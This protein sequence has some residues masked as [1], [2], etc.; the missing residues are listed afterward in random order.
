M[1]KSRKVREA[2]VWDGVVVDKS[3]GMTDGSSLYHY[4]EV[5]L[6]DGTAQKFRID[7][8]LWNSLNTG[9][10]LVKEAGAKA[11]VKG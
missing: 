1:F 9:D 2:D 8:A 6:Q 4:V 11:P 5:R 10:R 7:E 3:R